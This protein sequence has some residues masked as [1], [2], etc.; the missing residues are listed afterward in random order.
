MNSVTEI[1]E[2][3][4]SID[5]QKIRIRE[6]TKNDIELEKQ[7]VKE[8]SAETKHRRFLCSKSSLT[9]KELEDFCTIDHKQ[10]MAFIATIEKDN[11]EKMIGVSRY[12]ESIDNN[13]NSREMAITV[14]DD[15]QDKGLGAALTKQ[16]ISYA[17]MHGVGVMY[18]VDYYYN[19]F[20]RNLANELG[21]EHRADPDDMSLI[22]YQL[23]L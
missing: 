9:E 5:G 8:L 15:W 13:K 2:Q 12:A 21:I 1:A 19:D 16:L 7:F 3:Q 23:T 4:I 10:S 17:K 18:S 6:I 14:A 20:M 11:K 22:I